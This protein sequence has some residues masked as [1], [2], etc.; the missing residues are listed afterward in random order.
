MG[1]D[2]NNQSLIAIFKAKNISIWGSLMTMLN[3]AHFGG[4]YN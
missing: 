3:F 2:T 4:S 1:Q